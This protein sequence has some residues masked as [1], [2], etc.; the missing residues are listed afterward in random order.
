MRAM[1]LTAPGR[2]LRLVD[3]P[4][5]RARAGEI[6]VR[7]LAC[8]V[9]R[10]DLHVVD[11]ELPEPALPLVPGHEIVGTV[12]ELGEGVADFRLG[13]RVGIP[14]LGGTCGHC[15]H[16]RAGRENLCDEPVLTGYQAD[17]GYAEYARAAAAFCFALPTG[18]GD[19]EAAPLLC[20]GMVGYRAYTKAAGART[21][22]LYGFGAAAHIL[23]QLAVADGASVFAFT[24]PGD[25]AAQR[26]ARGLGA[27]WAGGSDEEPPE[28][29]DAAI[30]FAPVGALV[31][32]ALAALRKGGRVICGGIH[33]SDI[34]SFPYRLLWEER[35]IVSVANL[36]RED[37]HAFFAR[38]AST[39]I[40]VAATPYPLEEAN[41][42]LADLRAGRVTGAA[43]LVP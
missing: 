1:Q 42:A 25:T 12:V 19:V 36:T 6:V 41:A 29:L 4:R 13:Q 30:L 23:A 38:A 9:C 14:W 43:V 7:V 2:P 20:A 32:T 39:P 10:T 28:K 40:R 17:G 33:M 22:G 37:G 3:L 24:R 5:P 31:P 26:L 35:E 21:L 18:C 11:G 27:A 8:G 34:P 16:C 15:A